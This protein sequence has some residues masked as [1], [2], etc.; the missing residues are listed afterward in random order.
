MSNN[1][2]EVKIKIGEIE[3]Y[4]KGQTDDIEAQRLNFINIILPAAVDAIKNSRMPLAY[5]EARKVL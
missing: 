1:E 3:F 4:A 5:I 2:L